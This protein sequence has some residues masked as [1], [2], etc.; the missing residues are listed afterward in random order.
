[1]L[2]GQMEPIVDM[3]RINEQMK[4]RDTIIATL[5]PL[6]LICASPLRADTAKGVG[7]KLTIAAS[8][9]APSCKVTIEG[10]AE[11]NL[12]TTTVTDVK[13]AGIGAIVPSATKTTNVTF[14]QCNDA[15]YTL[16]FTGAQVSDF[17]NALANE[18]QDGAKGVGH[19]LKYIDASNAF[20]PNNTFLGNDDSSAEKHMDMTSTFTFQL[21]AGYMRLADA[22]TT[23]KTSSTVTLDVMQN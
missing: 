4:T 3:G 1:M 17:P 6:V 20:Y 7:A 9:V 11:I 22:V 5:I 8:L 18:R 21:E 13:K 12:A 19:Y 16:R 10:G 15:Q 2:L 23:G 14:D